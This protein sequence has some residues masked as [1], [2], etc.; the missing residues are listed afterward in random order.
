MTAG[1]R[2]RTNAGE[3]HPRAPDVRP[4]LKSEFE[5][6]LSA[7]GCPACTFL[8]SADRSFFSWFVSENHTVASVQAQL[9]AAMGMCA[10]HSRRLIDDPGP[11]P[12]VTTVV[13]EALTGAHARLRGPAPGGSCPACESALSRS[14]DVRHLVSNAL[15]HKS[16]ARH[17]TEHHGLCL[18]HALALAEA[19]PPAPMKLVAE[20]LLDE[21]RGHNP[22]TML[23]LL[24]GADDDASRRATWRTHLPDPGEAG[25]T[26]ATLCAQLSVNACPAC[27]AA[28]ISERRYLRWFQEASVGGDPSLATDPGE[29][30]ATHLHDL[31]LTD[32]AAARYAIDR[33]RS[34]TIAAL[35]R[36]LDQLAQPPNPRGRRR[37]S[38]TDVSD[39]V[40]TTLRPVH[41][42]PA[43]RA[44]RTAELRQVQLLDAALT[45]PVVQRAYENAHGLCVRH[46]LGLAGGTA[47][48]L[49]R[50]A[51]DGRV[52]VLR[53]ELEE[54]RRKYAWTCRHEPVG[55]EHDAWLRALVQ[56][57]GRLLGGGPANPNLA[58]M[59]E[60]SGE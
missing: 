24:A 21:L 35:Q 32:V 57:D 60:G 36:L 48:Q 40:H 29:F 34:A 8:A 31:A 26:V 50:R 49:V 59:A 37:A 33:K 47:G 53:W 42:C 54:I 45:L 9:R 56:V 10:R 38:G 15:L 6:L 44:E 28:G 58:S 22:S 39:R 27:L 13:R 41:Q 19:A 11:G 52:A 1:L 18:G 5:A 43:C 4:A 12:V 25:T 23:A 30:C 51:V 17:F 3:S 20:R 7:D 55:P 16:E 2:R 14:G 46:A